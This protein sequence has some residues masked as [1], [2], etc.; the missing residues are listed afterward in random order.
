MVL[1]WS[2]LVP[3]PSGTAMLG[4]GGIE[5]AARRGRARIQRQQAEQREHEAKLQHGDDTASEVTLLPTNQTTES[6]SIPERAKGGSILSPGSSMVS[7][8]P[9]LTEQRDGR[10]QRGGIKGKLGRFKKHLTG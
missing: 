7:D 5:G 10:K 9:T 3:G 2:A 6:V 8:A 1:D 4:E